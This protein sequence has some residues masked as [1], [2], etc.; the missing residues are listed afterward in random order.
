MTMPAQHSR[1]EFRATAFAAGAA[2]FGAAHIVEV[3]TWRV[4]FEPGLEQTPWFL[5][6]GRAVAFA[7]ACLFLTSLLYARMARRAQ[8]T[9]TAGAVALTAGAVVAMTIVLAVRGPGTIF[10]IAWT[11]GAL[12]LSAACSAGS[13]I[14][15]KL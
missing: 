4:L 7:A 11:V 10:P 6:S 2:A 13:F 9:W 15:T 12:I 5:N 8:T 3:L 14:A 1:R